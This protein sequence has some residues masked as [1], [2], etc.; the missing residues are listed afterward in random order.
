MGWSGCDHR[1]N[2][3][4]RDHG[5]NEA[6]IDQ[7]HGVTVPPSPA[8][9]SSPSPSPSSVSYHERVRREVYHVKLT[10][11]IQESLYVLQRQSGG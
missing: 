4:T 1:S 10:A 2:N 8:V 3:D 11:S 7:A 5:G 9:S 6:T